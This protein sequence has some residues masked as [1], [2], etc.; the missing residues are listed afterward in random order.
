MDFKILFTPVQIGHMVVP[1]RFVVPPMGTNLA[2]PDGTVSEEFIDYWE[3][4]ARGGWGLLIVEITAIDPL[5]KAIPYQPCLWDDKFI[6]GFKK[7]VDTVH[8]YGA[9]IAVQLHHAGRQTTPQ[10]IGQQPVAPSPVPCLISKEMPRELSVSEVYELIEKFGDAAVRAR[11]AGFD[12]V[13]VHGAHGYLVAQFMSQ[14]SN[15]RVDEFGGSFHNRMRFPVEV[16]KNIR[17]KVGGSYPIIFR[18]SA[19]EKVT[20]GRTVDESR[21][22]ARVIEAAGADALHVSV[23]VYGSMQ[24]IVP[25]ADVPPGFILSDA[26]EIK[27]AVSV[28]VIGVGRINDPVLA[29]DAILSGKADLVAWGRQSLADP[30]V[31]NKVS[32]GLIEDI[33]PCIACNQGCIGYIFN[34]EKM[35]AT[36]LVNPFCGRERRMK[37]EPAGRKKKVIIVG[38]GPGGLEAAWIAA[39]RGHNVILFEKENVTGGQ[40]RVGAIAPAKQDLAKAINFY[41]HMGKKYGVEYRLGVEANAEQILAENPDAVIIAT[42]AAP[43]IPDISGI[44][45]PNIVTSTEVLLG[46]KVPGAKVLIVG[47]GMVGCETADLLGEHGHEVTIVDMLPEIA[48]DVQDSV[49]YFLLKRLMERKIAIYTNTKVTEFIADGA[50]AEKDGK[51]MLF[52]GFDTIIIAVG[53]KPVNNLRYELEGKVPE[54]YIIGDALE[55]RKAIDAIEEGASVAIKL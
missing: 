33:S 47:G 29:V 34:P 9:K 25:P 54:L 48:T 49:R 10:I 35:K 46:I 4:R 50:K 44:D 6:P 3:A 30:E 19:D 8:R 45:N 2:N 11:E 31:P 55:A 23:G 53:A 12:A 32:A 5:G 14:H 17:R 43:N 38:G 37:I 40:F 39:A 24:Y 41:T 21:A 36:C 42:G 20:G 13:E 1:N 16:I 18:L 51:D 27:K 7:L 15:K 22:A 28:P 26:E 52:T